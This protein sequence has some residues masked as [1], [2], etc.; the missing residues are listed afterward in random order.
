M[1]RFEAPRC[2]RCDLKRTSTLTGATCSCP[3]MAA[4]ASIPKPCSYCGSVRA[5]KNRR[6][7]DIV[8]NGVVVETRTTTINTCDCR[9]VV[10][11]DRCQW[12]VMGKQHSPAEHEAG[13]ALRARNLA[14][15]GVLNPLSGWKELRWK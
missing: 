9:G 15:A 4:G 13:I 8:V 11:D 2:G 10:R 6:E 12:C 3:G 14:A 1:I 5:T 7:Y